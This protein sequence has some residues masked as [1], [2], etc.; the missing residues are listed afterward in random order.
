MTY[1]MSPDFFGAVYVELEQENVDKVA[2]LEREGI[3]PAA[4]IL[5]LEFLTREVHDSL[6]K[7]GGLRGDEAFEAAVA[8][9]MQVAW[10]GAKRV[11]EETTSS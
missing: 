6:N 1:E 10:E 7:L 11:R 4:W 2:W 8:T 3:N 9:A 5:F